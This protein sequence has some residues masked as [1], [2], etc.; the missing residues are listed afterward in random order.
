MDHSQGTRIDTGIERSS[1]IPLP[2]LVS[3]VDARHKII[4]KQE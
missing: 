1:L 2:R 3:A 4:S